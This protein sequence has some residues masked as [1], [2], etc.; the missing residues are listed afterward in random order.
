MLAFQ[1][2]KVIEKREKRLSLQH[3]REEKDDYLP[4]DAP[5]VYQL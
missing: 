3:E 5:M 4:V 1:A 2:A